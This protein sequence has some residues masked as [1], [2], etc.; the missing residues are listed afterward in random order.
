ML[1]IGL[2]LFVGFMLLAATVVFN[3]D[4]QDTVMTPI[5]RMM[6]MLEEI[7]KDPCN[8]CLLTIVILPDQESMKLG[9]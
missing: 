6:N 3:A 7:V 8:P 4:A 2:T 1:N 5:E 9:S